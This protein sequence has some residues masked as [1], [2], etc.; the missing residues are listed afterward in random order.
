M[1]WLAVVGD[2]VW[3]LAMSLI[4]GASRATWRLIPPHLRVPMPMILG[5]GAGWRASKPLALLATPA[6]ATAFG[7]ALSVAARRPPEFT[8]MSLIVF[9]LRM[10]TAPPFVLL[11]LMHLR[12]AVDTLAE[13]GQL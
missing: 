1:D 13:E 5:Q 9:G 2:A 3:I 8:G 11:H 10:L 7:L 6:V 12:R 4:A